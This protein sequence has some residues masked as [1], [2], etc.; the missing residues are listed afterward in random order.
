M[1]TNLFVL[2]GMLTL[3]ALGSNAQDFGGILSNGFEVSTNAE[4]SPSIGNLLNLT[5]FF[6]WKS[7]TWQF[8]SLGSLNY[9]YM[10][11]QGHLF[12]ANLDIFRLQFL[13]VGVLGDDSSLQLNLGRFNFT[14]TSRLVLNSNIDQLAL[15]LNIGLL[16]TA[17]GAGYSGLVS[18][19]TSQ[20]S[21]N[22]R[23]IIDAGDSSIYFSSPRLFAWFQL[24]WEPLP[25]S[26]MEAG[27]L[28]QQDMRPIF[29]DQYE[30]AKTGDLLFKPANPPPFDTNYFLLRLE[31]GL[32]NLGTNLLL[33]GALSQGTS[34]SHVLLEGYKEIPHLGW[35]LEGR[36]DWKTLEETGSLQFRGL[37]SSGDPAQRQY[38]YE[39]GSLSE[40]IPT[41]STFRSASPLGIGKVFQPMLGNLATAGLKWAHRP[42]KHPAFTLLSG[43]EYSLEVVSSFRMNQGAIST[44]V[45][46]SSDQNYLGTELIGGL[47]WNLMSDLSLS[48]TSAWFFANQTSGGIFQN[49]R[50]V[51]ENLNSLVLRVIF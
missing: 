31:W 40:E 28:R 35:A 37:L 13:F 11:D 27:Y 5:L 39:G 38:F 48:L 16:D 47:N 21:Y 46:T 1:K 15:V 41:L 42:W 10:G 20:I 6:D 29:A 3:L 36:V 30:P 50:E 45:N 12:H 44:A 9:D 49:V 51:F 32:P 4:S 22:L 14:D 19:Y 18:K 24:G 2:C 26:R 25:L 43:F 23:D 17:L 34:T 8:Q 33:A 7:E